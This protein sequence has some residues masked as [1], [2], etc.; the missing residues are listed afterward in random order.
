MSD[1][2]HGYYMEAGECEQFFPEAPVK[3]KGSGVA[4]RSCPNCDIMVERRI[5]QRPPPDYDWSRIYMVLKTEAT[6]ASNEAAKERARMKGQDHI[7][8][9]HTSLDYIIIEDDLHGEEEGGIEIDFDSDSF[10]SIIEEVGE[11]IVRDVE[12]RMF[13]AW[14]SPEFN[15]MGDRKP[16]KRSNE[17]NWGLKIGDV[18]VAINPRTG[19][20]QQCVLRIA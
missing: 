18:V 6:R 7:T 8:Y 3:Q 14:S 12:D 9:N 5:L 2:D 15:F 11:R 16:K 13:R 19:E 1:D 4:L 10:R 20:E 17:D